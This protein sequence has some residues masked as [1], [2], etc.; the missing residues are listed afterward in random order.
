MSP[1]ELFLSA[2]EIL[3][4]VP[5]DISSAFTG[6]TIIS[7]TAKSPSKKIVTVLFIVVVTSIVRWKEE[8]C[9]EKINNTYTLVYLTALPLP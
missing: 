8:R 7:N 4:A 5:I 6:D 3:I 9:Q 1:S 2:K